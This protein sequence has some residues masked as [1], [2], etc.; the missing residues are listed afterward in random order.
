MACQKKHFYWLLLS[1]IGLAAL[2][3]CKTHIPIT[4]KIFD[5]IA[6]PDVNIK[7]DAFQYYI[8]KKITLELVE[9][10]VPMQVENG[11]LKKETKNLRKRITLKG[12][13][14]GTVQSAVKRGD[15][16]LLV[17]GFEKDHLDCLMRF[18]RLYAD[19]ERY[20]LLYTNNQKQTIKYGDGDYNVIFNGYDPPYLLIEIKQK[21]NNKK[22]ARRAKGWKLGE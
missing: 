2:S 20:Y 3:G 21:E 18:G 4:K 14:P 8:S 16:Y 10:N 7:P 19:D 6:R 15:G 12:N 1:F 5:D 11:V 22:E 9:T 17:I 13:L